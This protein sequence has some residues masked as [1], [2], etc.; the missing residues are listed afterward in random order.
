MN[1]VHTFP[2]YFFKT[3]FN[4]IPLLTS[5]SSKWSLSFR[6]SY[7]NSVWISLLSHPF[8]MPYLR[9]AGYLLGLLFDPENGGTTLLATT[10]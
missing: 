3:D 1:P 8:F 4:I 7:Q 9:L 5:G 6:F 2:S 10:V